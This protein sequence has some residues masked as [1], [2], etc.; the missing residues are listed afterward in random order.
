[1]IKM[2]KILGVQEILEAGGVGYTWKMFRENHPKISSIF[3]FNMMYK[4]HFRRKQENA[5]IEK[6][7]K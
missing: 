5:G 4:L 1:M 2:K 6:K 3:P 7:E